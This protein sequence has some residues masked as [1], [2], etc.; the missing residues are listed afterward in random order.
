MSF[1][2][3]QVLIVITAAILFSALWV[4]NM[5]HSVQHDERLGQ[6]WLEGFDV[7]TV[8]RID[9]TG[10][11]SQEVSLERRADGWGVVQREHYSAQIGMIRKLLLSM[12]EAKLF[13]RKTDDAEQHAKLGLGEIDQP[14]ARGQQIKLT[15][16]GERV[17]R[18]GTQPSG[19]SA[20]YVRHGN[21]DQAWL[22]DRTFT[23]PDGAAALAGA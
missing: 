14:Q 1:R 19:R 10:P 8:R 11:N 5:K 18:I 4:I 17:V 2:E 20:T 3:L 23:I 16:D 7:N 9:I 21:E 22:V 12:S 15:G 13:E 6:L